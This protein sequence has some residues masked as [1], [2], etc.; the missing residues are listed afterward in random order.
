MTLVEMLIVVG[1]VSFV[2]VAIYTSFANGLKVWK[3]SQQLVIEEDVAIFFDKFSQHFY[4][5]F[6]HSQT[7]F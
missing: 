4:N 5:P 7:K 3:R 2:M 6:P 1:L